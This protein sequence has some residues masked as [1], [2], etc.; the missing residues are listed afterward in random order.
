MNK[1]TVEEV[2]AY[3][4]AFA[5]DDDGVTL[6]SEHWVKVRGMLREYADLLSCM[7]EQVA[8]VNHVVSGEI[9]LPIGMLL[10]AAPVPS[11]EAVKAAEILAKSADNHE[12]QIVAREIIRLAGK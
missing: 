11:D 12:A 4:T 8:T 5:D 10:F 9:D 3:V 2:Q 1:H 7:G 6:D